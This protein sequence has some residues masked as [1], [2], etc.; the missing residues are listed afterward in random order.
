[1]RVS[2]LLGISLGCFVIFGLSNLNIFLDI[3]FDL[4]ALTMTITTYMWLKKNVVLAGLIIHVLAYNFELLYSPLLP[5][6]GSLTTDS[7]AFLVKI[8][9][10]GILMIM[11]GLIDHHFGDRYL[12]NKSNIKLI[13]LSTSVIIGT[14][15]IQLGIR[16][17]G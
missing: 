6:S 4:I 13:T 14:V 17:F 8:E 9:I 16:S 10:V 12:N 15:I 11:A 3:L 2:Y 7:L 5:N 1:M